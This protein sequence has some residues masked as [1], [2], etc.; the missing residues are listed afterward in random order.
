MPILKTISVMGSFRDIEI[1]KFGFINDIESFRDAL[2]LLGGDL[3]R[4]GHELLISWSNDNIPAQSLDGRYSFK[5]TADFSVLIGYLSTALNNQNSIRNPFVHLVISNEMWNGV[6]NSKGELFEPVSSTIKIGAT[7][8]SLEDCVNRGLLQKRPVSGTEEDYLLRSDLLKDHIVPHADL[9]ISIGGGKATAGALQSARLENKL[10][11]LGFF[12][13]ASSQTLLEIYSSPTSRVLS[14]RIKY[15]MHGLSLEFKTYTQAQRLQ[16]LRQVAT[17]L[18]RF[19]RY[20]R[21]VFIAM[22]F[23][24]SVNLDPEYSHLTVYHAVRRAL[25]QLEDKWPGLELVRI[26]RTSQ[27]AS[28]IPSEIRETIRQ[29]GIFIAD[30]TELD[31]TDSNGITSPNPN[32]W[33]ELGFADGLGKDRVIL[34]ARKGTYRPFNNSTRRIVEW[35]NSEDIESAVREG[36][37]SWLKAS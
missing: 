15:V 3:A 13:G 8:I 24:D 37:E 25:K 19:V 16:A 22:P 28:D 21:R 17:N 7:N 27:T 6:T 33:W 12:G 31:R 18:D 35:D 11:P 36:I 10:L 30:L 5:D 23:R 29:C 1:Q 9:V 2:R 34:L 20:D 26:D 14:E 4:L 32:V